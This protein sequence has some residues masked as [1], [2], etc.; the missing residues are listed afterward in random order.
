V[1]RRQSQPGVDPGPT[2]LRQRS[3][4]RS[5]RGNHRWRL[6]LL[7]RTQ[8]CKTCDL[9]RYASLRKTLTRQISG[10]RGDGTWW[11]RSE[12]TRLQPRQLEPQ[13]QYYRQAQ[14][15]IR[16]LCRPTPP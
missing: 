8:N 6:A 16:C 3:Y 13:F 1:A 14:P 5:G 10:R 7:W 15:K 9:L 12:L 2:T 4:W 11:V